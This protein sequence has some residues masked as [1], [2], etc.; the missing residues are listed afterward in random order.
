[1][2]VVSLS[3]P[4]TLTPGTAENVQDVQD[5]DVYLAGQ[6]DATNAAL[7]AT[8]TA[9][10]VSSASGWRGKSIISTVESRSN[11]AYATLTTPDQVTGIVLPGR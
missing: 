8:N 3:L 6:I 2:G 1:M 4:H 5:N 9:A 7:G 11:T 10:G